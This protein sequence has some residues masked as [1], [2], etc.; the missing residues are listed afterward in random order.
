MIKL[1]QFPTYTIKQHKNLSHFG[2]KNFS[3]NE[4]LEKLLFFSVITTV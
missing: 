4:T 3:P 1:T 2:F